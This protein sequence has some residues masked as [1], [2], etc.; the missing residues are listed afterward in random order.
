MPQ[1]S[2]NQLK[3]HEAKVD[4]LLL[5]TRGGAILFFHTMENLCFLMVICRVQNFLKGEMLLP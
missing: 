5:R 3:T 1:D 2:R 4:A